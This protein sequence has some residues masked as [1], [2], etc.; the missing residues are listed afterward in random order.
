MRL[1][2]YLKLAKWVVLIRISKSSEWERTW[3]LAESR[4]VQDMCVPQG[5]QGTGLVR[6]DAGQVVWHLPAVSMAWSDS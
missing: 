4:S 2:L 3:P 5:K 6:N 1:Y